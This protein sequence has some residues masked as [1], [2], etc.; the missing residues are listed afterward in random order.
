MPPVI[1]FHMG[2][3]GFLTT[4]SAAEFTTPLS[5][6]LVGDIPLTVRTRLEYSIIRKGDQKVRTFSIDYFNGEDSYKHPKV[7]IENNRDYIDP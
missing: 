1:S 5:R 7:L 6:M 3:L 4:F 2:T